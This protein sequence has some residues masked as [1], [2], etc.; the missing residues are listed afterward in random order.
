MSH[1]QKLLGIAARSVGALGLVLRAV[2][3]HS[4]GARAAD[5]P[6]HQQQ[7]RSRQRRGARATGSTGRALVPAAEL[8][9]RHGAAEPGQD[10]FSWCGWKNGG[11]PVQLGAVQADAYGQVAAR[12]ICVSA[13]TVMLFP[14]AGRGTT[15]QGGRT[16]AAPAARLRRPR[17]QL[18][19]V[20]AAGTP[21]AQREAAESRHGHRGR[22]R[23]GRRDG[24]DRRRRRTRRRSRAHQRLRRRLERHRH[25]AAGSQLG[26][27]RELEVRRGRDRGVSERHRARRHHDHHTRSRVSLHPRHAS[28][29]TRPGG[30]IFAAA[31]IPRGEPL[32]FTV[33]V[34]AKLRASLDINLGCDQKKLFDFSVPFVY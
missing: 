1:R 33:N 30:S 2:T 29:A 10:P 34:N 7:Q 27:A 20:D 9:R 19:G 3:V 13:T 5:L 14:S 23:L 28:R 17:R 32:G 25:P 22:R 24:G 18:H 21:L 4:V 6:G 31:A 26:T 15:C 12:A 11:N 8:P 16:D